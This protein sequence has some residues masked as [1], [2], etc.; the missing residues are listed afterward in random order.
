MPAMPRLAVFSFLL[1]YALQPARGGELYV[2]YWNVENLFDTEDDPKVEGD[3]EFT[4]TGAKQWTKERLEIKLQ[5]LSRAIMDMNGRK[6]PDVLGLAEIENRFVL[7]ELVK[8]LKPVGRDYRIIHKD[9]PSG[10]GIDCALLYDAKRMKE[11]AARFHF[12]KAGNTRDIVEAELE[13]EG[14]RLTVFVNHWPSRRSENGKPNAE[15]RHAAGATLRRRF[16]EL[17]KANAH[18]DIVSLGDLN[19]NPDDDSVRKH[20]RAGPDQK[21]L[22]AGELFNTSVALQKDAD[23]KPQ[24]TLVYMNKWDL[25]DQVIVSPGL[26]DDKGFTWKSSEIVKAAYLIFTPKKAEEIPRPNRSY[27]GNLFH[28]TGYSDHLPVG[29]V[30]RY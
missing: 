13:A 17:L 5:N 11:I 18:A 10:R 22:Q 15:L 16:D 1:L 25:F 20:L 23:G 12:V 4:P 6:G 3:E 24:G 2:A 14:R 26:L 30:I 7:E 8:V 9:S 19:D 21:S 29:C 28:K 27:S